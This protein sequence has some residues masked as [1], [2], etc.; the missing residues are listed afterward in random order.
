M[1]LKRLVRFF[2][3][4]RLLIPLQVDS[5][6]LQ[7][8]SVPLQVDSVPLQADSVP[9]QVLAASLFPQNTGSGQNSVPLEVLGS[10]KSCNI[11]ESARGVELVN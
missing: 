1:R 5:V 7:V 4:G 10:F 6:P 8:D 11:V 3:F 9:F 2:R